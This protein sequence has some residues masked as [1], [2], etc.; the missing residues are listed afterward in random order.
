VT[1]G[2]G[3]DNHS[4]VHPRFLK[5]MADANVGHAP[6]YGTDEWTRRSEEIIKGHFGSHAETFFV[7][8]GTAAN[9]LS[10]AALIQ[11]YHA[12][13]VASQAHLINDECGA[14]E[15]AVGCKM[16]SIPTEDGKLTPELIKPHLVRRG[17]QHASQ[18]RM[19]SITQSTETGQVYELD[20][21]RA[22]GEFARREGLYLHVDGA[23]LV[24]AAAALDCSLGAM[25]TDCGVDV[26]S[27]GGT[28]NG[29]LFGEAVVFL[30]SGLSK[31][32]RF[33]RKQ[34][35]QLP[36]KTRFISAQFNE[37]LGTDL[38]K[39]NGKHANAMAQYLAS[40]LATSKHAKITQ[41][42]RANAVFAL[43]PKRFVSK[44]RETAF[45]YVWN[46]ATFECRLMTT[47]D[48]Q[49]EEID[50]FVTHLEQLGESDS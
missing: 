16:I 24:N 44:L 43:I 26:V 41:I 50:R 28:K 42:P 30:K 9:V 3:S 33:I 22:L 13:L 18:V 15:D 14:P 36:S 6:S 2:F 11:P 40:R 19:I 31:D 29:L 21:L 48:T 23:R 39:E 1:R 8:N 34:K 49:K 27:L 5:A 47:W 25:T 17:D 12:V 4:G 32:F 20:E 46:E 37:F 35:M 10:L 38:W 45:F 7:F